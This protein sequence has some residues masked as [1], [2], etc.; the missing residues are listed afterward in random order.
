MEI[1]T[2][3]GQMQCAKNMKMDVDSIHIQFCSNN[4]AQYTST[5]NHQTTFSSQEMGSLKH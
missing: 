4:R 1:L 5:V 3:K 2:P